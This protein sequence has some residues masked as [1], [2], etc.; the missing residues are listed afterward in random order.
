MMLVGGAI[1]VDRALRTEG[2][3]WWPDEELSAVDFQELIAAYVARKP[4]VMVTHDCPAEVAS[5]LLSR[6]PLPGPRR[7]DMPSRTRYALQDMWSAHAPKLWLF[8]HYHVSFDHVLGGGRETGTRFICLAEL[9]Y[10]DIDL[11]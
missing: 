10:R 7:Q 3:D 8:A 4:R 9:E 5:I 11:P 1:S 2:R 6:A